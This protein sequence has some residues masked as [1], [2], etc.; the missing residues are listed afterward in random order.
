MLLSKTLSGLRLI[1]CWLCRRSFTTSSKYAARWNVTSSHDTT[2]WQRVTC[3][4]AAVTCTWLVSRQMSSFVFYFFYNYAKCLLVFS[5]AFYDYTGKSLN[6]CCR[7]LLFVAESLL[8]AT[9]SIYR[10]YALWITSC[11]RWRFWVLY[12]VK[13]PYRHCQCRIWNN[14]VF[15]FVLSKHWPCYHVTAKS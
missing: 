7:Y 6:L 2:L 1:I 3:T 15:I 5:K 11:Y 13:A 12:K 14:T 9:N 8:F 4:S 10:T